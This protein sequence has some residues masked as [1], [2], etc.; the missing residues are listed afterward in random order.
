M[1]QNTKV[2]FDERCKLIG[3]RL[4]SMFQPFIELYY[5]I[6]TRTIAWEWCTAIFCVASLLLTFRFDVWVFRK[7]HLTLI[8]PTHPYLYWPYYT[9]I[10]GSGFLAWAGRETMKR[11]MIAKLLTEVFVCAGLKSKMG[12]LPAF[13]F[14]KPLDFY[15]RKLKV[16]NARLPLSEFKKSRE[17]IESALRIYID[18]IKEARSDGTIEMTYSH[19]PMPDVCKLGPLDAIGKM[20]YVVGHTRATQLKSNFESIPH[21]LIAGQTNS[22]KSTFL[23]QLV[24]T[25]YLNNDQFHFTL[26]DL[27]EGLEFQLFENLKRVSVVCNLPHA[28]AVLQTFQALLENRMKLLKKNKCKDLSAFLHMPGDKRTNKLD[29]GQEV[30]LNRHLIVIDEAADIFLAGPDA[31]S[32]EI[33]KARRVLVEIARKGRAVGLHLV[34][35]TQRPDAKSIDSQI[36][37][38]LPGIIC[39]QM[40]NDASSMTVLGNGR[41]TDLPPIPGRAIWKAG[42]DMIEVQTPL[43]TPE[44]AEVLLKP[45]RIEIPVQAAP[46]AKLTLVPTTEVTT[47][48]TDRYEQT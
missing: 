5:G 37:A 46:T 32:S 41:A 39:F 10:T 3:I 7:A 15:T 14:D 4:R 22:G 17:T 6:K 13:I 20:R 26:I 1:S 44:E 40:P 16:T 23:R 29:D 33:Q 45:Y 11:R 36:K 18:D 35:A 30:S 43:L 47:K 34:F 48:S 9:A 28:A 24:T 31:S 12:R 19:F 8:Y 27:K 21:L 38:N 25:T 2:T 42:S